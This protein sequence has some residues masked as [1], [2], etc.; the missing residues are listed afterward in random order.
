MKKIVT[1]I[2][3]VCLGI[4]IVGC[5]SSN[6]LQGSEV[7]TLELPSSSTPS[8]LSEFIIECEL[9]KV[10]ENVEV[11]EP[12]NIREANGSINYPHAGYTYSNKDALLP[13][14][15]TK[16]AKEFLAEKGVDVSNENINVMV[17]SSITSNDGKV[18]ALTI[19]MYAPREIKGLR[20]YDGDIIVRV[21]K[22]YKIVGYKN[23][24]FDLVS[25]GNYKIISPKQ[26]VNL[27]PKYMDTLD[28][29]ILSKVGNITDV[30]LCYFSLVQNNIQP[31]YV[32]EGYTYKNN[33][34][35]KF[36]II[37]PAIK[38]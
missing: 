19:S 23:T 21:A 27:I 26:A 37:I 4:S 7:K 13:E 29:S 5:A 20:L 24:E 28:G 22:G 33:K 14:V 34:D 3:I 1:L 31:V 36:R 25:K 15:A 17:S 10:P 12:S 38:Q 8:Y 6:A 18:D 32:I 16:V 2:C 30:N 9:P 35:E 11:F